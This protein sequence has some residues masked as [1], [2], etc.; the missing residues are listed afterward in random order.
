MSK[1]QLIPSRDSLNP[2]LSRV[3]TVTSDYLRTLE[4]GISYGFKRRDW[5]TKKMPVF[6]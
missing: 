4:N 6:G 1:Y 2:K 5:S 3:F